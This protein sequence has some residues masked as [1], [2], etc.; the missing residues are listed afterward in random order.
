VIQPDRFAL[1][2]D[3]QVMVG[4]AGQPDDIGHRQ[5]RAAAGEPFTRGGLQLVEVVVR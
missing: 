2:E 4:V 1:V 3:R 5:Q